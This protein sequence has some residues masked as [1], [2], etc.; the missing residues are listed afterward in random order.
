[1]PKVNKKKVKR[2]YET[3]NQVA[4]LGYRKNNKMIKVHKEYIY[5]KPNIP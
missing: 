5:I 3:P 2:K 1:M 4:Y